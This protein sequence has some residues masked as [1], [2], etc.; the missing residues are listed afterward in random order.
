MNAMPCHAMQC[1]RVLTNTTTT[2]TTTVTTRLASIDEIVSHGIP[3]E[4]VLSR[5]CAVCGS[6]DVAHASSRRVEHGTM[7]GRDMTVVVVV[8]LV[9]IVITA[10]TH[11]WSVFWEW[12]KSN[13]ME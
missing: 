9:R 12:T 11:V 5:C 4:Q 10:P 1:E 13:E 2:T 8:G 7:D 3:F 6:R